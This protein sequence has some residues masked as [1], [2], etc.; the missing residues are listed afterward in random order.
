MRVEFIFLPMLLRDRARLRLSSAYA[1]HMPWL[2]DTAG[3]G[4]QKELRRCRDL[5][6]GTA[7]VKPW[8]DSAL[9]RTRPTM[10]PTGD[11]HGFARKLV[12]RD[13]QLVAEVKKIDGLVLESE[14]LREPVALDHD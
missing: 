1:V 13:F 6:A 14:D 11:M 8:P 4:I 2:D 9:P 3:E 7:P 5:R 10:K 12:T